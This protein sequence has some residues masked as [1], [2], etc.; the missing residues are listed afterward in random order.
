VDGDTA[1]TEASGY[2]DQGEPSG[3]VHALVRSGDTWTLEQKLT[4]VN[5]PD[6]KNFGKSVAVD[7]S[8]AVIGAPGF[9]ARTDGGPGPMGV[10]SRIVASVVE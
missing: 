2:N 10:S 6:R 3:S 7:G 8:T 4:P 5:G 1:L 9:N